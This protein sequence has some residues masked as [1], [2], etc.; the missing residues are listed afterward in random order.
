MVKSLGKEAYEA[1][2]NQTTQK[3]SLMKE[4][5]IA[6]AN[7]DTSGHTKVSMKLNIRKRR[8]GKVSMKF[9]IRK[10]RFG[11]EIYCHVCEKW[12]W[13]KIIPESYACECGKKI[14]IFMYST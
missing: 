14:S 3:L 9:K 2:R 13:F 4:A 7:E 8:F 12:T 6:L 1:A 11:V 10:K 5:F